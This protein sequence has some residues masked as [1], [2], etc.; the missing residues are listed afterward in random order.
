MVFIILQIAIIIGIILHV[1]AQGLSISAVLKAPDKFGGD[2]ISLRY[3]GKVISTSY[4]QIATS[5]NFVCAAIC[6]LIV[7]NDRRY[8]IPILLTMSAFMPSMATMFL[9]G[10]KGTLPQ[11]IAFYC[12]GLFVG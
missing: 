12:G 1:Y 10:D 5:L 4:I 11:S 3:S 8:L 7:A 6:G 9:F 2:F